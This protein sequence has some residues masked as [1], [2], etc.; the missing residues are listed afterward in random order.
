MA[1]QEALSSA[2]SDMHGDLLVLAFNRACLGG[3]LAVA[4]SLLQ[5][6]DAVLLGGSMGWEQRETSL[7]LMR[8]MRDR[9]D[10]L[11]DDARAELPSGAYEPQ[12]HLA[13]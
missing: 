3:D 9:L 6:L 8:T 2:A 5:R 7:K 10:D 4:S 11:R 13:V 12:Q 1:M